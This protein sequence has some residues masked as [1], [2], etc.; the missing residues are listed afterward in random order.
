[1]DAVGCFEADCEPVGLTCEEPQT[2]AATLRA[3]IRATTTA[4]PATITSTPAT[5][6]ARIGLREFIT[7]GLD[8]AVRN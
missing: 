3:P 5:T 1:M 8:T 4:T 2:P 7:V 6:T